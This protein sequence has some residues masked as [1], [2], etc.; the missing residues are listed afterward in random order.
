MIVSLLALVA[1]LTT[2]SSSPRHV[3]TMRLDFTG[4]GQDE[5][6]VYEVSGKSWNSPF[7][8]SV[9]ISSAGKTIFR[10]ISSDAWLDKFF[11]DVGY[12]QGCGN[13]RSCKEK[14]Y[15]HDLPEGLSVRLPEEA[16]KNILDPSAPNGLFA[17]ARTELLRCCS[18]N[19]DAVDRAIADLA[20]F[21]RSGRA[22]IL[23]IPRSPVQSLPPLAWCR[24]FGRFVRIYEE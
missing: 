16:R 10:H 13:Y 22:L 5:R 4:D 6:L 9:T 19:Q 21:V 17:E 23:N 18:R 24:G 1:W 7:S 8:W 12:V 11:G 3:V 14:Y 2:P 20:D 15:F